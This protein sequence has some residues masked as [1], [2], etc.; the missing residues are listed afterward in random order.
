[1]DFDRKYSAV[2]DEETIELCYS[3][4]LE[5]TKRVKPTG[6]M[7][8]TA[9][10]SSSFYYDPYGWGRSM[11]SSSSSGWS[12]GPIELPPELLASTMEPYDWDKIIKIINEKVRQ[13]GYDVVIDKIASL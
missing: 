3:N 7:T 10:P 4:G 8:I 13:Y 2:T 1:M 12:S 11:T 6:E 5:I 9:N